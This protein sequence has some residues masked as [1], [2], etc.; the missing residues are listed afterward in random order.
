MVDY[1]L[2]KK[3]KD[4]GFSQQPLKVI[5]W[6][7]TGNSAARYRTVTFTPSEGEVKIPSLS[8]LIEACGRLNEKAD[9]L[10]VCEGDD[11]M[12]GFSTWHGIEQENDWQKGKTPEEAVAKLWLAIN[13]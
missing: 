13:K 2:A 7:V 8:E 12:A 9:R 6:Y 11:W 10:V 4:A 1:N 3:L 5:S